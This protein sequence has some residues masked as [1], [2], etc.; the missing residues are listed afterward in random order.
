MKNAWIYAFLIW[1]ISVFVGSYFT[2]IYMEFGESEGFGS[3]FESY[4]FIIFMSGL[5]S[6]PTAIVFCVSMEILSVF[7]LQNRNML[8]IICLKAYI[9]CFI[10]LYIFFFNKSDLSENLLDP[11]FWIIFFCYCIGLSTGIFGL[12]KW[13]ILSNK[14]ETVQV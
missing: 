2:T 6:I 5:N 4:L 1:I 7:K 9:L 11:S 13:H 3:I 10:T 14:K 8:L 12:A